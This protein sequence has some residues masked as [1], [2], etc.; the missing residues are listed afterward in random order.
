[1]HTAYI[2]GY[3]HTVMLQHHFLP[4]CQPGLRE[5]VRVRVH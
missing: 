3:V 5:R 2:C 1:M 4:G